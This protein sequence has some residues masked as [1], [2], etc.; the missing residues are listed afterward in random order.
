MRPLWGGP[1]EEALGEGEVRAGSGRV[2]SLGE[3]TKKMG[4]VWPLP[5]NWACLKS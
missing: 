1:L 4:Q 3:A 2:F 5:P